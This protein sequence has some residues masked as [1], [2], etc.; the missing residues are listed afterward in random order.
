MT[1]ARLRKLTGWI[2]ALAVA[3]VLAF[4]LWIGMT[5]GTS[6]TISW[7]LWTCSR[8]F[9]VL[10]LLAGWEGRGIFTRARQKREEARRA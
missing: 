3:G 2:C 7:Q 6:T 5:F 9:P 8:R 1:D 4:D 10:P